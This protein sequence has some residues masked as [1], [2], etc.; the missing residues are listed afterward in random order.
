MVRIPALLYRLRPGNVVCKTG[1]GFYFVLFQV[2]RIFGQDVKTITNLMAKFARTGSVADAARRPRRRVTT[3][4]QDAM[5]ADLQEVYR[6]RPATETARQ[7]IGIHQ[8]PVSDITV[9]RRLRELGPRARRHYR[10][11]VLI[12]CD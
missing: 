1:K 5:I 7:I 8:R 12:R 11:I 10:G 6:F 9:R 2:A 3:R 4:D